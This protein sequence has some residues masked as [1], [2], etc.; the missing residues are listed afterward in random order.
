[1]RA[2]QISHDFKHL[3]GGYGLELCPSKP[4][5]VKLMQ[6]WFQE[7]FEAFIDLQLDLLCI[8]PYDQG[9]CS[10]ADCSP[11]GSNGF[12][13]MAEKIAT[14][15]RQFFP[16]I[17][18][19][20]ST[21]LFDRNPNEINGEWEGMAAKLTNSPSWV[22]YILADAHFDFPEYPLK[23]G[24]P[25]NLPLINF[26]E[27]SMWEMNPWGGYGA[28]PLPQRFQNA[29]NSIGAHLSG[30]LPYSEGIFEDINK[31]IWSQ[32]YWDSA[33]T[34]SETVL[35][36]LQ[37]EFPNCNASE[38]LKA[39]FILEQNHQKF[40]IK[41]ISREK[42]HDY[43]SE[44]AYRIFQKNDVNFAEFTKTSWRWRILFLRAF[45]DFERYCDQHYPN[46]PVKQAFE[47]LNTIYHTQTGHRHV[48]PPF[49]K[50]HKL[51]SKIA[52]IFRK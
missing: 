14:L 3:H 17:E 50:I 37:Y 25:G 27:I 46:E 35:E 2:D 41:R 6:Q 28:N 33:K 40:S 24:I 10:C 22:N 18:I 34:A 32:F 11:W 21:W 39:I 30:G 20:L 9:G 12:L 43:G 13:Q 36:Y 7:E 47:E 45:L 48:K 52:R 38:L 5:A 23:N 8:W 42:L 51:H 44:I 26:P 1:M 16:Q 4:E 15:A 49:G 31:V 19:I 29:W